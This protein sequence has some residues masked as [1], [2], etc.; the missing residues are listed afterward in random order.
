MRYQQGPDEPEVT[1]ETSH[2]VLYLWSHLPR[3]N[4]QHTPIG[5]QATVVS[6][7]ALQEQAG[8]TEVTS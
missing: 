7:T 1:L 3:E 2:R 4:R 5:A 6:I 8:E